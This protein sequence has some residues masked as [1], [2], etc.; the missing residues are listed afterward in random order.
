MVATPPVNPALMPTAANRC[1]VS[2]R[3]C[4][5][6][7]CTQG[8]LELPLKRTPTSAKPCGSAPPDA[9]ETTR[10]LR[11]L[12]LAPLAAPAGRSR[13]P[14]FGFQCASVAVTAAIV[15][16]SVAVS[17]A[18]SRRLTST[19][20]VDVPLASPNASRPNFSAF[21]DSYLDGR[22]D[23]W[24]SV[25]TSAA[26]YAPA[27]LR[28][29]AARS[30][31]AITSQGCRVTAEVSLAKNTLSPSRMGGLHARCA[32]AP[33]PLGRIESRCGRTRG[34]PWS[35]LQVG[36]LTRAHEGKE[37]P[38]L[39]RA[40]VLWVRG[41]SVDGRPAPGCVTTREITPRH[42]EML[43]NWSPSPPSTTEF[44]PW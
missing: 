22:N 3:N 35:P 24:S 30:Q 8:S 2:A 28:P 17:R 4:L 14:Q 9:A 36:R 37:Q 23:A 25:V 38:L 42:R 21:A 1:R 7:A 43:T 34:R 11:S 15:C 20:V 29:N 19:V 44:R 40:R 16:V 6:A 41:W 32:P 27:L 13:V 18:A 12:S 26:L 39:P 5:N 31:M 10:V 33:R